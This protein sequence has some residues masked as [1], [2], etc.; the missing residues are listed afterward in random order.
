MSTKPPQ[1]N[2]NIPPHLLESSSDGDKFIM[3]Q[4]SV[5]GQ[6]SDWLMNET[7]QQSEVLETHSKKLECVG[8][9]LNFTNGKIAAAMISI[10]TLQRQKEAEKARDE[11]LAQIIMAKKFAERYF[12]NKWAAIVLLAVILGMIDIFKI[13]QINS[14]VTSLIGS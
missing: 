6:K 14:F 4:L 2:S 13:P 1:F 11:E 8:E 7:C 5:M 10:D 9:K 12:F 3:E